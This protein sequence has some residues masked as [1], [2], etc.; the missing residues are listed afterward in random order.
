MKYVILFSLFFL[1][2][3]KDSH[4]SKMIM[5]KKGS[6]EILNNIYYNASKGL[7]DVDTYLISKLYYNNDYF[8]EI[9]PE[10]QF[11]ELDREAYFI[12]DSSYF[13]LGHP[14]NIPSLDIFSYTK[15][16][17]ATPLIYKDKGALFGNDSIPFYSSRKNMTDT[18][19]FNKNFARFEIENEYSYS[20]YYIYK[21]DTILPYSI[22]RQVETD[23]NG[24]LERIDTYNKT[25]DIFITVQLLQ[26]KTV[27]E[28]VES[29]FEYTDF[30]K[31]QR[32]T[33][34]RK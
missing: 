24:R 30:L 4:N 12:I 33:D 10:L 31:N 9:V 5:D 22:N 29:F 7:S 21:T 2:G 26:D 23:Y 6:V 13:I 14:D 11:P 18:V 17:T 3:C 8:I 28:R 16:N 25:S 20:R 27:D 34:G 15:K 19:L 1:I 32:K